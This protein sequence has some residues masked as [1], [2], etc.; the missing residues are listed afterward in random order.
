MSPLSL[1]LLLFPILLP[2]AAPTTIKH[3]D[4]PYHVTK[5]AKVGGD[6]GFDYVYADSADRRLYV[7][8]GG[9]GARV[10][11]YDLDTLTLVGEIA[12]TNARGAATDAKYHHGFSS[13]SPVAMWDSKTLAVIKTIPV[14]G[15]PDGILSDP[16]NHR[17][18]VFSHSEPNVTVIDANDGSVLGTIDLGG[19]PEQAVTDGRG[20]VYIDLEDKDKIAVVDAKT[21]KMTGTYDLAGKGGGPGG[22]AIDA[23]NHILFATC[24]DPQTVVILDARDGK[25]LETLPIG[26]GTDGATFNPATG[27]AFSSQGDGTLTVIKETS[28]TTFVVEQNVATTQGAKTLTIDTKTGRILLIAAEY[29]PAP[30]PDPAAPA[31]AGRRQRRPMLP[32]SFTILVVDK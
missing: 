30:T 26:R 9:A 22:L 18:Y 24:H 23:K 10:S 28:P 20:H 8:R 1:S 11:A 14:Q 17:V 6:G 21:M 2:G 32:G 19:A 29:G 5:R 25:I 27:E 12:N 7:A 4:G 3:Q 15:R 16:F 31:P 13:S